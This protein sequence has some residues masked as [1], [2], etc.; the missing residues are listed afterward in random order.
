MYSADD[1]G[2]Y[3]HKGV[4][5]YSKYEVMRLTGNIG[6][7]KWNYNDEFF[8]SFDWTK[9]PTESLPTLYEKR[10]AA[11]R[12]KYD[13]LILMYSGGGDSG[14]ILEAFV[15]NNIHLDEI[16]QYTNVK[17]SGDPYDFKNKEVFT[18]AHPKVQRYIEQY[19]L[20]TKS[21]LV[22]ITDSLLGTYDEKTKFDFVHWINSYSSPNGVQRCKFYKNVK[23]WRD[24]VAQ[25]KKIALIWG[26]DK[27]RIKAKDGE[28]HFYF[29]DI[30]EGAINLRE[31]HLGYDG[32]VDE[33]F[34]WSP[35]TE[36]ARI[37]IK[38]GH[39]IK[40]L[41][42]NKHHQKLIKHYKYKPDEE[43]PVRYSYGVDNFVYGGN[44]LKYLIYPY[45]DVAD[46]CS[47]KTT[48]GHFLSQGDKWFTTNT[49]ERPVKIYLQGI[50]HFTKTI[51]PNWILDWH[52]KF[53]EF[54]GKQ[55]PKRIVKINS[56]DY[57]L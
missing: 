55:Y 4:K 12:Q 15:R 10:A 31:Q 54:Q 33:L 23:E 48:H 36:S 57:K 45:W 11:L 39:V 22:D 27:P 50:E 51:H 43:T 34:Y 20:K 21:R 41:L 32:A 40:N 1:Y 7:V 42:S 2:F 38:Q 26:C 56:K 9:E 47:L 37:L 17:G 53:I 13:Y 6:D 28:F 25:G 19:K 14:N 30:L 18:V 46:E 44:P 5:T 24:L 52:G 29:I 49:N 3:M 35:T 8:S 16:C